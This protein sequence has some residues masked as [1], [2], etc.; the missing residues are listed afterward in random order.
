[1]SVLKYGGI[2]FLS[3][4][5]TRSGSKGK[6]PPALLDLGRYGAEECIS[7]M[8][9]AVHKHS[10]DATSPILTPGHQITFSL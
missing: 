6:V 5:K 10:L 7:V 2:F 1:M 8:K 9:K 4:L 3:L